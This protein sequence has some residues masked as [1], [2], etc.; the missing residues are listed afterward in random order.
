MEQCCDNQQ[1]LIAVKWYREGEKRTEI[2]PSDNQYSGGVLAV[3]SL[4]IK[5]TI[6][7][8]A[9]RYLCIL[10]Y[11]N[12]VTKTFSFKLKIIPQ[13]KIYKAIL[14]HRKDKT[15]LKP[16]VCN[17]IDI[18]MQ[19]NNIVVITGREGT[20][21]SKI[22]LELA[23]FYEN[24]DHMI[25]K[26]D[27]SEN[28]TIYTDIVHPLILLII[29]DEKYT[30]DSL[31]DF[32][33]HH[34]Q[35]LLKR[36]TKVILTCR[37]FDLDIVKSVPEINKLKNEAF[38]D[39]NSCLTAK[40]KEQMLKRH[41]KVNNIAI[42]ASS[43]G[44]FKDPKLLT[45]LSVQVTLDEHAIKK[46]KNEEPWKG[47]P[48]CASLFCSE[49]IFLHLGEKYFINPP[50]FLV[51]ELK[52]L[53]KTARKNSNSIDRVNEY[54][55]L[56]Y[57]LVNSNHYLD[58]NDH[59]LCRKL[60]EL[61]QILFRF[62]FIPENPGSNED[63]K[64]SI[65]KAAYRMNNKY[66]KLHDGI[67]K[68]IHPCMSIAMF[69]SSDYMVL[70][71]LQIGSLHD[72]TELIRSE[73][74]TALENELVIKIDTEYHHI[75]CERLVRHVFENHVLLELVA[76]YIYLYW[77]SSGNE[78]VNKMFSHIEF[79]F[80]QRFGIHTENLQP[81]GNDSLSDHS[82]TLENK[83]SFHNIIVLNDQLTCQ[84]RY[85]WIYR[86]DA[87][88]FCI[89]SGLVTAAIGK[90]ATNRKQTFRILLSEFQRRI[91][92]ESFAELWSKPLDFHGNTFF[93][94]LMLFRQEEACLILWVNE[95]R[96]ILFDTENVH[97]Y[98]PLDFAAYLG[99]VKILEV[100]NLKTNVSKK[101][102]D[103]LQRLAKSGKNEFYNEHTKKTT[104]D[105][106]V[107]H[108]IKDEGASPGNLQC[109]DVGDEKEDI[110]KLLKRASS[111]SKNKHIKAKKQVKNESE[112]EFDDVLCFDVFMMNIVDFGENEDYQSSIKLLCK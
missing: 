18:Q 108:K 51:E 39:I 70:Y 98:T 92:S 94:Y 57:I 90:Y 65:E 69:L 22:C 47:F 78:L 61:Y 33:K 59:N 109:E 76:Q 40:E 54:C 83:V 20:G 30:Q 107:I 106:S 80:Y 74:Y 101:I 112:S 97:K 27:L 73:V 2:D 53:Y 45:D 6:S 103:R 64:I 5:Q 58:L 81:L 71:L 104:Y 89:L 14:E 67:Y 77:S 49:R 88:D 50:R 12:E 66:L 23:S 35:V 82:I 110:K 43:Q 11:D 86:H 8:N 4:T 56:V 24:N 38:I 31:N 19:E 111:R 72:I 62:E 85:P 46:I 100:L 105:Q 63:Q 3:P 55:I 21:K 52:E 32:M 7:E 95:G 36:N 102:K 48:V 75:L 99:K 96:K 60:A 26:A 44:N 79:V 84:G 91:Q 16:A 41:M 13:V 15:F 34:S 28:Y 42:S 93:H 29:D 87:A 1:T 37:N 17:T 10:I 25:I 9:G 68:F